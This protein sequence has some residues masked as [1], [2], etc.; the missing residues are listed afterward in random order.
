MIVSPTITNGDWGFIRNSSASN[1]SNESRTAIVFICWQLKYK[2]KN[3]K[4]GIKA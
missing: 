1:F 2:P 3:T 4:L